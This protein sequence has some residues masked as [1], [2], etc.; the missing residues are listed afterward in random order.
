LLKRGNDNISLKDFGKEISLGIIESSK[1]LSH[2]HHNVVGKI[3]E[4][5]DHPEMTPSGQI[6]KIMMQKDQGFFEFAKDKS[7]EIMKSLKEFKISNQDLEN[8]TKQ[9]DLSFA[10]QKQIESEDKTS[11]DEYLKEYFSK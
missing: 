3:I 2:E 10:A 11:F 8:L 5:F 4:R 7:D 9:S 6:L 1:I